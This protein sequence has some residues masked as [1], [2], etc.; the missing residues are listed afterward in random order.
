MYREKLLSQLEMFED[1]QKKCYIGNI[2]EAVELKKQILS[3]AKKIDK[4]DKGAD[5][6]IN[7]TLDSDTIY[8]EIKKN[9]IGS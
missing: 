3:I 8:K 7:T 4:I 6:T 2:Y 9:C 5:V 1:L